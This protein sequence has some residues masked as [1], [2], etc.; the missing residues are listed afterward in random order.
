MEIF[1]SFFCSLSLFM[2]PLVSLCFCLPPSSLPTTMSVSKFDALKS[3]AE[4]REASHTDSPYGPMMNSI[5]FN[6]TGELRTNT[7]I[8]NEHGG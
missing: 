4:S 6:R 5:Q 1:R 3:Q 2:L 7:V 8:S